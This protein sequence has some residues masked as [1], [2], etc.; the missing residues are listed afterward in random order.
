[1]VLWESSRW[2]LDIKQ[3]VTG[4]TFSI[5]SDTSPKNTQPSLP[6]QEVAFLSWELRALDVLIHSGY[7]NKAIV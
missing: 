1:M 4:A 3:E 5:L 7:V 6:R 2:R